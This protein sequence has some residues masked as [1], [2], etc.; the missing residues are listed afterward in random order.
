M[1][2]NN[3]YTNN[4]PNPK[5]SSKIEFSSLELVNALF[6]K[7]FWIPSPE[8]MKAKKNHEEFLE[9]KRSEKLTLNPA[10]GEHLIMMQIN[11]KKSA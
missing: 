10:V 2:K 5:I 8:Y 7:K 6:I 4:E 3:E 9:W 1:K 11:S